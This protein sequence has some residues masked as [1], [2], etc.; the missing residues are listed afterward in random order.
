MHKPNPGTA[1][2]PCNQTT[3]SYTGLEQIHALTSESTRLFVKG[4]ALL[5]GHKRFEDFTIVYGIA[6]GFPGAAVW[7]FI[8]V[9]SYT[10]SRH[11]PYSTA[12]DPKGTKHPRESAVNTIRHG[13]HVVTSTY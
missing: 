7:A 1:L 12:R 11:I 13:N 8:F 5:A 9:V 3:F 4:M 10:L 2:V 6:D